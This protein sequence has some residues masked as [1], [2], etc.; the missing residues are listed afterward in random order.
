MSYNRSPIESVPVRLVRAGRTAGR[1]VAQQSRPPLGPAQRGASQAGCRMGS[2]QSS[3][4]RGKP[5]GGDPEASINHNE[6][7]LE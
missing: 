2:F 1:L 5:D 6:S 3:L 7:E 4:R